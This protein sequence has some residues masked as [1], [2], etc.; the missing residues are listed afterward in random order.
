MK[1]I[2]APL[3][4]LLFITMGGLY[5][6]LRE[7][8]STHKTPSTNTPVHISISNPQKILF[9]LEIIT[10]KRTLHPD[11]YE[12]INPIAYVI[13]NGIIQSVR[14][15]LLLDMTKPTHIALVWEEKQK[16]PTV[17][18]SLPSQQGVQ[19]AENLSRNLKPYGTIQQNGF[20][21]HGN[22]QLPQMPKTSLS[23]EGTTTQI[24]LAWR[25]FQSNKP[26]DLSTFTPSSIPNSTIIQFNTEHTPFQEI[27]ISHLKINV[28]NTSK[29]L[30]LN[31]VGQWNHVHTPKASYPLEMIAG[32]S[33]PGIP[34]FQIYKSSTSNFCLAGDYTKI[35]KYLKITEKCDLKD[36]KGIFALVSQ[37]IFSHIDIPLQHIA[38]SVWGSDQN[39][40]IQGI[41]IKEKSRGLFPFYVWLYPL[42]VNH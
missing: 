34:P 15:Y 20:Q 39:F 25:P 22:I 24:L 23:W 19:G 4:S 37:D 41:L 1:R 12:L 3:A 33:I 10:E 13:T 32:W 38:I 29:T 21:W 9:F 8:T 17:L 14:G 7:P 11:W 31:G 27:K 16:K 36:T 2:I 30:R 42:I 28:T 26:F 5:F 6:F 40:S 35:Q 18:L